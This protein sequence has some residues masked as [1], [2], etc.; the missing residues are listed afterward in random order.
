MHKLP[1]AL[2]AL[3][4]ALL[5]FAF[6]PV[7]LAQNAT[8]PIVVVTQPGNADPTPSMAEVLMGIALAIIAAIAGYFKNRE[9][10]L[11]KHNTELTKDKEFQKQAIQ[12][13]AT[14]GAKAVIANMDGTVTQE[15]YDDL[16]N[17]G[18]ALV[19]EYG[20]QFGV[21]DQ[22]RSILNGLKPPKAT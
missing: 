12:A 8:Q 9:T 1:T 10:G 14:F 22:V 3:A 19:Q 15:E 16:M 5:A 13:L 17:G 2:G 21:G 11:V 18:A 4:I 7:A 20:D 6:L